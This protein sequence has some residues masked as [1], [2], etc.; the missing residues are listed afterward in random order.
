MCRLMAIRCNPNYPYSGGTRSDLPTNS[1][2]S[3]HIRLIATLIKLK[4]AAKTPARSILELFQDGLC[5]EINADK[6]NKISVVQRPRELGN[7]ILQYMFY[8]AKPLEMRVLT[9]MVRRA[10]K[11]RLGPA[12]LDPFCTNKV[13]FMC[14]SIFFAIRNFPSKQGEAV[15]AERARLPELHT[16]L[17]NHKRHMLAYGL[18]PWHIA[19]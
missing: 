13:T 8:S 17:K 6:P 4:G 12:V 2:I 1:N 3:S 10:S 19:R 14:K 5:N 7:Q 18:A 16:K 9:S 11:G 15:L